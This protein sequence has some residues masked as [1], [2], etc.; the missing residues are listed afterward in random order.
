MV[1]YPFNGNLN[2]NEIFSSIYNMI[3]SQ[4]FLKVALADNYALVDK[5]K[6]D[7]TLYGDTKLFYDH[8]VLK[9]RA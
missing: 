8:D 9:S 2:P 6:V 7:G 3:I 5:F 1:K 4:E